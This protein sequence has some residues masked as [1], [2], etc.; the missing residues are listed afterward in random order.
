MTTY[1]KPGK[2][3]SHQMVKGFAG[4]HCNSSDTSDQVNE[5]SALDVGSKGRMRSVIIG[6]FSV[7][8][9][10]A[11]SG[12]GYADQASTL[13]ADF[14]TPPDAYKSQP[15]WHL[16]GTLETEEIQR[17]LQDAQ[18]KSGFSGIAPLPVNQTRPDYL[19]EGYF[20]L[21]G[22][23]LDISKSLGMEV[24]FYDEIG[25]PS[26]G[27]GGL[28]NE[29]YPEHILS[30]LDMLER[31]VTG[32]E[33]VT[34][35]LPEGVHMAAVAMNT[36]TLERREM[37]LSPDQ[38]QVVFD[39]PAGAWKL[40]VFTSVRH[41]S[42]NST[43][44]Y[45]NPA[46]VEKFL[47]LT[48]DAYYEQFPDHFGS[49]I[50]MT[51]FDDVGLR[52]AQRRNWTPIFNEAFEAQHGYAPTLLY[53]ALWRDIGPETAA[54]RV[55]LLGFRA[56]LLAN[57]YPRK[58]QEWAAR[59][60]VQSSGHAM[61]QYHPQPT[62]LGGDHIK[63]YKHVDIPM[64]DSIHYYGHG[65]PGFKLTSS[66][67]YTYDRP[68]TAVEI[69]GNYRSHFDSDMLYRSGM[70]LFARGANMFLPHGMWYDP[71]NVRIP[72]L[73]S[74]FNPDIADDLADYND[75]VGRCALLLRGGKHIADIAVLYPIAAMQAHAILDA[76]VDQ[77]GVEGNVH[78]GLYVPPECDFNLLSDS[79]TGGVRRDFTF[80][81]PEILDEQCVVAG[82]LLKLENEH[83]QQE[84]KAI[85]IPGG[86]VIHWSNLQKIK[87]F[88]EAG[89]IVV[90]TTALPDQSAEFGH[91]E[92]VQQTIAHIFGVSPDASLPD[93][94]FIANEHENGGM[95]YFIP[96]LDNNGTALDAALKEAIP[97]A[98]VQFGANVPAFKHQP[99]PG[100]R[101]PE[102]AF[103]GMLSYLH[104]VK[105]GR[106]IYF[107]A[108]S[109]DEHIDSEITLRG[110][111][112]LQSWNPHDGSI[113][114]IESDQQSANDAP[115]TR[116]RLTLAPLQSVF[117]VEEH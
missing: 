12:A 58:I 61:G 113:R 53:P 95:A 52:K 104:K 91:D 18:E 38:E 63:F 75:W 101:P 76:V 72:P 11:L 106:H 41:E 14:A 108:N 24:I 107:F 45:L 31:E 33:T 34:I 39:V 42:N 51:Y 67:S 89:G 85:L 55:A 65:R 82:S 84:Y 6:T 117:W 56:E 44:D 81:H 49:T 73:I 16:N 87:A 23:I 105:E 83:N 1:L 20:D 43:V 94:K 46:S 26:G 70:E 97:I 93:T 77:H 48:Y 74:D 92:D 100:S 96:T 35:D 2:R 40:M 4:H 66:A 21:Y 71:Q 109:T 115:V 22:D 28:F 112:R 15:L 3:V 88:Y 30:R 50:K 69:Y 36:Q 32:P 29:H 86:R 7:F 19:T 62:F 79:L 78:P 47:S 5:L 102:V 57:G 27:A 13:E 37:P 68:H 25:F 116:A 64:M 80:L 9:A 111:L 103:S 8:I 10:I 110:N 98:D 90:A 99:Q 114:K 60:G 59:R 17:Q 54:A